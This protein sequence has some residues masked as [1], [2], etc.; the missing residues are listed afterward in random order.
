MLTQATQHLISTVRDA[1]SSDA[2]VQVAA[3]SFFTATSRVSVGETN[4]ALSALA[5]FLR[6]AF[7]ALVCGALVERGCEPLGG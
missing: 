1:A 3:Q 7:L 2:E 6:A 4:D 5:G